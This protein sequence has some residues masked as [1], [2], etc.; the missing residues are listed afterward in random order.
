M[1]QINTKIG[2]ESVRVKLP[3]FMKTSN[4]MVI[5]ID[6][7]HAG[8]NSIVGVVASTN[9]HCSSF[10]SDIIIQKKYQEIV[11]NDLDKFLDRALNDFQTNV[12]SLPDRLVIFR[13]GMGEGCRVNHV[14]KE[15]SQ[16]REALANRFNTMNPPKITLILVNKR[17]NQRIFV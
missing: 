14:N 5:G 9:A 17:I 1:K 7:C 8:M 13:D 4:V 6:V 15:I 3:D 10:Y 2:G 12:G 11:K 16:F